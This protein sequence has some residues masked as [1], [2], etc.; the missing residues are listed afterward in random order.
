MIPFKKFNWFALITWK[1]LKL[2]IVLACFACQ[3]I[4][5]CGSLNLKEIS[6]LFKKHKYLL[7]A[8]P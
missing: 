3:L 6:N 4:N 1:A 8:F 2:K 7:A 5:I